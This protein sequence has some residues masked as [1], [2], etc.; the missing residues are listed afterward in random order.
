MTLIGANMTKEISRRSFLKKTAALGAASAVGDCL[1]PGLLGDGVKKAWAAEIPVLSAVKG[2]DYYQNTIEAVKQLGGM[3]KFVPG[4]S[5]VGLLINNPFRHH[6]S[7]VNPDVSLAVLKMCL[8]AGA[9]EVVDLKSPPAGYWK[10]K[11]KSK[12]LTQELKALSPS[13]GN[14]I[15]K[16]IPMGKTL[17]KAEILEDLLECDVFI[18]L[19]IAKDHEGTRFSGVLKNM[20][21]SA[22]YS[23]NRFFHTGSGVGGYYGDV[24]FLSQCIA[25]INLIRQPDLCL[26]DCTI[27]MTTNGPF[28]PGDLAKPETVVA[29]TD[30]VALDAYCCRFLGLDPQDVI[31]L[32]KAVDNGLGRMDLNQVNVRTTTLG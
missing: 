14:Y 3:E 20:M 31:M 32:K 2:P 22:P 13:S 1:A 23:T 19:S 25:D 11:S 9:G 7:H 17:K 28:G 27:I 15:Q 8:D 6:G 16:E 4:D 10:N 5:R 12:D 30:R 21:G 26:A 18:N 24:D 29:C